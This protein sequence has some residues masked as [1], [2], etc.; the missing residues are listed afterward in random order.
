MPH[1]QAANGGARGPLQTEGRCAGA[2]KDSSLWASI[3]RFLRVNSSRLG[4]FSTASVIREPFSGQQR[5][6]IHLKH[7]VHPR[8]MFDIYSPLSAASPDL[9][10]STH[11]GS[12]LSSRA[13]GE[14]SAHPQS[15]CTAYLQYAVD[16]RRSRYHRARLQSSLQ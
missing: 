13:F 15:F 5:V 6:E 4:C 2:L 8:D 14:A 10:S 7:Q 1:S 11:A 3:A 12:H 16:E 9:H